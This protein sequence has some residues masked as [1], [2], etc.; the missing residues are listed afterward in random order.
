M[1]TVTIGRNVTSAVW[2]VTLCYPIWH[3]SSRSGDACYKLPYLVTLLYTL[4]K[5][6]A[7][8]HLIIPAAAQVINETVNSVVCGVLDQTAISASC[9]A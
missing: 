5:D 6:K 1:A 7:L 9:K 2:Q 8:K 4:K 3:V